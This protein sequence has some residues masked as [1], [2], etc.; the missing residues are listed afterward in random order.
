MEQEYKLIIKIK[1]TL[2][3]YENP[4]PM[5]GVVRRFDVRAAERG[6]HSLGKD[7][8]AFVRPGTELSY[9]IHSLLVLK[10]EVKRFQTN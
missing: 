10:W 6:H 1:A 4:D 5:I 7:A 2:K 8:S 3:I 9:L